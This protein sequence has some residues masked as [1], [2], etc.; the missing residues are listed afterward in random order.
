MHDT[1][2][3]EIALYEKRTPKSAAAHKRALLDA[4]SD[5]TVI[6]RAFSGRPA[7]GIKNTAA[8]NN[9]TKVQ[10]RSCFRPKAR[11]SSAASRMGRR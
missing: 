1:L 9:P 4:K 7:R 5:M 11:N 8:K 2:Q 3:K 10:A 6:T